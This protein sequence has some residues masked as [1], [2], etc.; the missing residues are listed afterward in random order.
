M[1]PAQVNDA[2]VKDAQEASIVCAVRDLEKIARNL[3]R[4]GGM[5][6]GYM[7]IHIGAGN[8]EYFYQITHQQDGYREDG[9]AKEKGAIYVF[10]P[11]LPIA[12]ERLKQAL[13][14]PKPEES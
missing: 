10:A 14:L 8:P 3:A 4:R 11:S 9:F 12:V 6:S 2:L 7:N 5:V 13:A 1:I